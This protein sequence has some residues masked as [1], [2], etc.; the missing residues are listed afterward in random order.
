MCQDSMGMPSPS[1]TCCANTVLP[2]PGSPLSKSGRSNAMAQL[3]A[4]T[5]ALEAM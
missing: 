5:S 3:T 1:A 2:V 4:S